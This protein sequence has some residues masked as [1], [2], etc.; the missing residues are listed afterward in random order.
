MPSWRHWFVSFEL[1]PY[2][3]T[4]RWPP[5]LTWFRNLEYETSTSPAWPDREGQHPE[6]IQNLG[7]SRVPR[8]L[9]DHSKSAV[10]S[11][12]LLCLK[13]TDRPYLSADKQAL[14]VAGHWQA[15]IASPEQQRICFEQSCRLGNLRVCSDEISGMEATWWYNR[16]LIFVRK[17][18]KIWKTKS[19]E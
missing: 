5:V 16:K 10:P 1:H 3:C 15:S 19:T 7:A 17:S 4:S 18:C 8:T 2:K 11:N 12:H 14:T 13:N 9:R 6:V